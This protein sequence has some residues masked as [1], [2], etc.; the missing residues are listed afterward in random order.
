MILF[1]HCVGA[2]MHG[3]GEDS[4]LLYY[5]VAAV[6]LTLKVESRSA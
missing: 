2:L 4:I 6:Y 1:D 3:D 5:L